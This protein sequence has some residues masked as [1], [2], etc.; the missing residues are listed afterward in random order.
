[1]LSNRKETESSEEKEQDEE[2][3]NKMKMKRRKMERGKKFNTLTRR[4]R[5]K[6]C[7]SEPYKPLYTWQ[8]PLPTLGHHMSPRERERER[9]RERGRKVESIV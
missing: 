2:K 6:G 7:K 8:M 3:R 9:E 4:K 1:M 5:F